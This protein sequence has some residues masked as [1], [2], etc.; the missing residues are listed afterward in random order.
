MR[1]RVCREPVLRRGRG[2]EFFSFFCSPLGK[3]IFCTKLCKKQKSPHFL[4]RLRKCRDEMY[5]VTTLLHHILADMTSTST[6]ARALYSAA[7]TGAPVAAYFA[8]KHLGTKLAKCIRLSFP[9]VLHQPTALCRVEKA[10]SFSVITFNVDILSP[11]FL[12][13]KYSF[14]IFSLIFEFL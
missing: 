2:I 7:V 11:F 14:K 1:V 6:K 13:V 8:K 5:R 4:I 10:Y 12:F 9:A 3:Y